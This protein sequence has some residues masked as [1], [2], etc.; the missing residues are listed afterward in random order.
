MYN[1]ADLKK[2]VNTAILNLSYNEEAVRLNDPVR[3][4]LSIGGKRL[5]PVLALMTCNLF[6]EKI[7]DAGD[8]IAD[9][10]G[11]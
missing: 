6:S 11:W 3:Y 1:Q 10:F 4:I 5:R 9:I 8:F 2:L 7:D